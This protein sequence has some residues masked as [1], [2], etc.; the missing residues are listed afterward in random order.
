MDGKK[1]FTCK[2]TYPI[3]A[4]QVL[5]QSPT[6]QDPPVYFRPGWHHLDVWSQ[7]ALVESPFR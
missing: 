3:V 2:T 6:Q 7:Q 1:T 5:L 4:K